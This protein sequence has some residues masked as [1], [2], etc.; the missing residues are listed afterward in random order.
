MNLMFKKSL[1]RILPY[2][3]FLIHRLVSF[4][5]RVKFIE[6]ESLREDI[7]NK[8]P[9][10]LANWHGEQ[11]GMFLTILRYKVIIMTS[12]S[13]D[14]AIM[15]RFVE[16]YGAKTVRG[17]SSNGGAGALRSM[18]RLA[19]EGYIP[20]VSV[21]GPRGPFH[22]IKPG[23]FEVSRLC[24]AKIYPGVMVVSSSWPLKKT[25][26]KSFFPKPFCK[27]VIYW[28]EPMG[29]IKREDDT[30]GESLAK[31]LTEKFEITREMALKYIVDGTPGC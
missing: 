25:W 11:S 26:D 1:D 6:C 18:I 14:G 9:F 2:I 30:R 10:V 20:T 4:T 29:P 13:R 19:R 17:S 24:N 31:E 5:W 28:G 23:I 22:V 8:R 21:D 16:L 15:T 7:K 27:M 12:L 3:I